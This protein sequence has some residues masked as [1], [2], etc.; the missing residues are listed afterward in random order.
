MKSEMMTKSNKKK[1]SRAETDYTQ[2]AIKLKFKDEKS[3]RQQLQSRE[4]NNDE[5][6][7]ENLI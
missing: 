5:E 3:M 7:Q 4:L 1:Q 2:L 6:K